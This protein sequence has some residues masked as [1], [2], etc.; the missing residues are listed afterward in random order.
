[1]PRNSDGTYDLP[2]GNPVATGT[3]ISS[4]WANDTL[5]DIAATLADSL[6]RTGK[7]GMEV[8]WQFDDG[9]VAAPGISFALEGNTGFFRQAAG[10]LAVAVGGIFTALWEAT[11]STFKTDVRIEGDL[12]VTGTI[13]RGAG[14]S[15]VSTG[16]SS[17]THGADTVETD[18]TGSETT[19]FD[20]GGGPVLVA[21]QPVSG[22]IL[23]GC[24]LTTGA[25]NAAATV[26]LYQKVN[27]SGYT[28][29]AAWR[30]WGYGTGATIWFNPPT[31][32]DTPAAGTGLQYKLTVQVS[33]ADAEVSV[34]E[35]KL[36]AY[37]L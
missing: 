8:P 29:I 26:R 21:L 20:P 24:S 5:N 36:V 28:A 13:S 35:Q 15:G 10:K 2:A 1:M 11:L 25:V 14:T 4:T 22:G 16:T 12:V 32:I 6:S 37:E 7:G 27:G 31:F 30:W 9:N 33:A 17:F 23:A 19:A 34:L 18:V 3:E